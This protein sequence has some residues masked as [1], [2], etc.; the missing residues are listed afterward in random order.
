MR[1]VVVDPDAL[2][3][4]YIGATAQATVGLG[5][6]ANVLVGGLR[7]SI[8]LQ[9]VSLQGQTGLNVAAGI[10]WIDLAYDRRPMS[11]RVTRTPLLESLLRP[12]VALPADGT[13]RIAVGRVWRPDVR[14]PSLVRLSGEEVIDITADY[15]TCRDL[16]EEP[17][18]AEALKRC[19][20]QPIGRIADLLANSEEGRRDF[21]QAV[22]SRPH[23]PPGD[24]GGRSHVCRLA[25]RKG[26]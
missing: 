23:R 1:P 18:P 6:G 8:A 16:C 3:G 24:Q 7:K 22:L 20:G 5:L 12:E 17:E 21:G 26:H 25:H 2:E 15:A 14:G 9:P 19:A 10:G 11:S 4:T 13:T